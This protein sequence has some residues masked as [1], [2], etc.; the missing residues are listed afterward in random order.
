MH[1]ST[2]VVL[3]L[4]TLF[5]SSQGSGLTFAAL[6]DW[7][8]I[9]GT[10]GDYHAHDEAVV[11]KQFAIT[12]A[13]VDAKFILNTGDNFYYCGVES[14]TDS[15][16]NVT[17]ENV[18]TGPSMMVP[19][20]SCL[21]NHDYG[22]PNS[23]ISEIQYQ[24]PN[25]NRWVLPDR[26]YYKRLVFPGQVNI[27]LVVLDASPCQQVYRSSNPSGWDPCGSVIP[28]CGPPPDCPGCPSCSFHQN[29]IE[30]SCENQSS[31][32]QS[33]LPTI[34]EGDWK[35]AMAHAPADALD[36][37]D[38][39]SMLQNA[40]F[41][42]FLNGHVHLLAHYTMDGAGTYIT[43]GAGC[44]VRVPAENAT[45]LRLVQ[46]SSQWGRE[47]LFVFKHGHSTHRQSHV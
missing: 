11:A 25:N 40:K 45:D 15:Q 20:Y 17:Y 2:F 29:V 14:K 10:G 31:W 19:W 16:W 33:V 26:Y 4:A 23:A 5:C 7:G 36:V 22:Y 47:L 3:V 27:S 9:G 12:A 42:L 28:S 6:G 8:C 30:Q 13:A 21:G 44:M 41:D 43:S 18:F 35:I 37:V 46:R 1:T 34:P 39:T 24:S 38:L 32:L